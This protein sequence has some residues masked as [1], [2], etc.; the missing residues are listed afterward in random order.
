M[1]LHVINVISN[2]IVLKTD[3]S[4]IRVHAPPCNRSYCVS[5]ATVSLF[6][7]YLTGVK[8]G[9]PEMTG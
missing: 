2:I 3:I 6:I 5:A 9:N 7:H 1:S 8:P 4:D